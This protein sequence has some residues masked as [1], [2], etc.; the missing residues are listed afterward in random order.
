MA[1]AAP[2]SPKLGINTKFN[3]VF[4]DAHKAVILNTIFT[5]P[6][7]DKVLPTEPTGAQMEYPINNINI[8]M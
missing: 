5:F 7:L 2:I 6:I 1:L 4:I 8:G 3:I